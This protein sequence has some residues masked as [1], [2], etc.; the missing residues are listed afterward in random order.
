[1]SDGWRMEGMGGRSEI[2]G[3]S[4]GKEWMSD[5]TVKVSLWGLAQWEG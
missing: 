4:D 5:G 3:V 1:V 2:E